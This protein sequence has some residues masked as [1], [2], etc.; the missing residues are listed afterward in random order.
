MLRIATLSS[1]LAASSVIS[2]SALVVADED[3]A[4]GFL[5][6][7]DWG[8]QSSFPYYTKEEKVTAG[9]MDSLAS[10]PK[11]GFALA[12]GDNFY[13]TGVKSVSDRRFEE[14]FEK[15]F[16]GSN[17]QDPFT[18]HVLGGNHDHNGNI[19]AQIA[20]SDVSKRWS[21]PSLYYGLNVTLNGKDVLILMIDTVVLSGNSDVVEGDVVV[22]ERSGRELGE[23]WRRE[24]TEEQRA[25]ADDQMNWI[26]DELSASSEADFVI[27][28][29]H[30][31]VWSICE[32]GPTSNLVDKLKP[33]MERFSVTA[34]LNG[35]DHCAQHI[36]EN[37]VD[38]HTIGSAHLNDPSTSHKSA[39]PKDSLQFHAEG[40]TGGFGQVWINDDGDLV[41]THYD[42]D[43]KVLYQA[44]PRSPR[45]NARQDA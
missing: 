3:S 19:T 13:S 32:H 2:S 8:G 43:G 23:H 45:S 14:T 5:V 9:G 35:H 27:V 36:K 11:V 29:G 15:V 31:P 38:Y 7:G 24:A 44:P 42:G 20:Y 26:M 1:F 6:M 22:H 30:Y 25:A 39:I 17:L 33:A 41:V 12:L 40:A 18:F 16:D 34:Y 21:Y 4:K 10:D 37:G 28:A